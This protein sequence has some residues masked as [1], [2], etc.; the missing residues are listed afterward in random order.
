MQPCKI[1]VIVL[2]ENR[3]FKNVKLIVSHTFFQTRQLEQ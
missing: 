3:Y 1:Y 2:L